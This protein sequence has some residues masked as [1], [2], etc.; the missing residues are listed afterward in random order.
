MPLVGILPHRAPVAVRPST[1]IAD[2]ARVMWARQVSALVVGT[3]G[4][5]ISIVT[6]RDLTQALA[7]GC[8]PGSGV[9]TI[10]TADPLTVT[11]ETGVL[12]AAVLMLTKGVR[13]LVVVPP[14]AAHRT[15]AVGFI[16]FE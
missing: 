16:P 10:A 8:D 4:N 2:A 1:S 15:S 11:P 5:L 7:D 9:L 14:C 6:E 13:H 12:E 3:P